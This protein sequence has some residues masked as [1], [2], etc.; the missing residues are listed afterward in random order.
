MDARSLII[1][2]CFNKPAPTRVLSAV[3]IPA[4]LALGR[5][6]FASPRSASPKV[7]PLFCGSVRPLVP[8]LSPVGG[9]LYRRIEW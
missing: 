4:F 7:V 1:S 6:E 5:H 9:T 8:A 3:P 2:I